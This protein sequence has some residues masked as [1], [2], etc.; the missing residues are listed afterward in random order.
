MVALKA[1][2]PAIPRLLVPESGFISVCGLC[3]AS[4]RKSFMGPMIK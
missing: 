1:I 3:Q 2:I 4:Q